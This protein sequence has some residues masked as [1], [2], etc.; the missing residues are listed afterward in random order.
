M[1]DGPADIVFFGGNIYTIDDKNPKVEAL[2]VKGERILAVGDFDVIKQ[3]IKY[4]QTQLIDLKGKRLLPGF[5]NAHEHATLAAAGRFFYTDIS[6]YGLNGEE[7]DKE[8]V[9]EIMRNEIAQT[10]SEEEPL[11]WCLFSGWDIELIPDLPTFSA[12][13]LDEFST[14]IPLMVVAQNL[15]AA[16][17]NNKTFEVCN[18]TSPD[19]CP[20][21]VYMLQMKMGN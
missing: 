10:D 21:G 11:P 19:Q 8:V 20:P 17:V 16:W 18:I 2:A 3:M 12:K 15:H 13:V 4:Q 14:K 1:N 7:R 5:V 6:A 9:L